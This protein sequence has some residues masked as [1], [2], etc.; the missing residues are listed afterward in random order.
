MDWGLGE[1]SGWFGISGFCS[2]LI[3]ICKG[4]VLLVFLGIKV[5]ELDALLGLFDLLGSRLTAWLTFEHVDGVELCGRRVGTRATLWGLN[6]FFIGRLR[7][8]FLFWGNQ[9]HR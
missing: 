9:A 6:T 1:T 8:V 2:R 5:I 4:V 7:G 3:R